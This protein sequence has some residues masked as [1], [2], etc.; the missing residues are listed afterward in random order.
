MCP[1]RSPRSPHLLSVRGHSD[2]LA[3]AHLSYNKLDL[4]K[5]WKSF[6]RMAGAS[7]AAIEP[8]RQ[9]QN[10]NRQQ[11]FYH[12]RVPSSA[13][14]RHTPPSEGRHPVRRRRARSTCTILTVKW[15]IVR[16][17]R[18]MP[19]RGSTGELVIN[20]SAR[21]RGESHVRAD[22]SSALLEVP[23]KALRFASFELQDRQP[24]F[25]DE[26]RCDHAL[27]CALCLIFWPVLSAPSR[28]RLGSAGEI[29]SE[30][31]LLLKRLRLN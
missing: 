2:V 10:G 18:E 31:T 12:R 5:P 17:Q 7:D 24:P 23:S 29:G 6:F 26:W 4:P 11:A 16:L 19:V 27:H 22:H 15:L 25:D 3:T 21:G 20:F 13:R 28:R 1:P 30:P 9:A 14:P 8:G